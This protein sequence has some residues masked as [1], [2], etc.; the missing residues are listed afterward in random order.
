MF[1]WH[2]NG[3]ATDA[4]WLKQAT[5]QL[6]EERKREKA[7]RWKIATQSYFTLEEMLRANT[8]QACLEPSTAA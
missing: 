6:I 3:F 7:Q 4:E 8:K 5:P 2:N 1:R